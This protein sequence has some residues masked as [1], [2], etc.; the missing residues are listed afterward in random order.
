MIGAFAVVN[1]ISYPLSPVSHRLRVVM[2]PCSNFRVAGNVPTG[3][4]LLPTPVTLRIYQNFP[5]RL[6]L[7]GTNIGLGMNGPIISRRGKPTAPKLRDGPRK[8]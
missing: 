8:K 4:N 6:R 2:H 5:V 3:L 7:A 1:L